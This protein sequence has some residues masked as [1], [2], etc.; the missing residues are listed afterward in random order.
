MSFKFISW[1]LWKEKS[2]KTFEDEE[3]IK[4]VLIDRGA[5]RFQCGK[6]DKGVK[7]GQEK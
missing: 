4:T 3:D 1:F 7:A 5:V 6:G 2:N